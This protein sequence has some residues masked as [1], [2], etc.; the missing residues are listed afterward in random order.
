MGLTVARNEKAEKISTAKNIGISAVVVNYNGSKILAGCIST[1]LNQTRPPLEIILVDNGSTDDSVRMVREKFPEV[2]VLRCEVN[3]GYAEGNNIGSKVAQGEFLVLVNNDAELDSRCLE[4]LSTSLS[5]E[6]DLVAVQG[7]VLRQGQPSTL[8]SSGSYLTP[9]GFLYHI[10]FD[11]PDTHVKESYVF[12]AKGVCMMIR[13]D[14]FHYLGGF[15]SDYFAYFEESD[16]CWRAWIAGYKVKV[17]PT[18]LTYHMVG[19]TSTKFTRGFID[20]HSF[21]N[22]IC[23]IIKNCESPNLLFMLASHLTVCILIIAGLTVKN[24]KQRAVGILRALVW[25]G[26]NLR[27]TLK[28]RQFIQSELRKV[29]DRVIFQELLVSPGLRYYWGLF[30]GYF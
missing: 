10:G 4:Q 5:S 21:K 6:P 20:Y 14:L 26:T 29:S 18:S 12:S 15:D 8:D 24:Q 11:K 17:V 30:N 7:K 3:L 19:Y 28:K 25:N 23:S 1:L 16:F 2:N 9:I 27:L 13:R 22:R